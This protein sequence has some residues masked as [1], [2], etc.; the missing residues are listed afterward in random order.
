LGS[1]WR[2]SG[3]ALADGPGGDSSCLFTLLSSVVVGRT[4]V[5]G[6]GSH[7]TACM[8]R[9][10]LFR[11]RTWGRTVVII[12]RGYRLHMCSRTAVGGHVEIGGCPAH[13]TAAS[14]SP[15]LPDR[16]QATA[17]AIQHPASSGEKP[18]GV[19]GRAMRERGLE[20]L[21]WWCPGDGIV[22]D[23]RRDA[24]HA[25]VSSGGADKPS[26]ALSIGCSRLAYSHPSHFTPSTPSQ[27]FQPSQPALN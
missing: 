27:P 13:A 2:R 26:F 8:H 19:R 4:S 23:G 6:L 10:R 24:D 11:Q 7:Y 9:H 5:V 25:D 20:G 15:S 16:R 21:G 18:S 17:A 12:G 14:C 1:G 22:V 3:R